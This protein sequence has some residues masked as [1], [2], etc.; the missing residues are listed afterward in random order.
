MTHCTAMIRLTRGK[1][2]C[3]LSAVVL[4]GA[5]GLGGALHVAYTRPIGM[6][7]TGETLPSHCSISDALKREARVSNPSLVQQPDPNRLEL[8][9]H[10]HCFW[11]QT[12]GADGIDRRILA[13]HLYDHGKRAEAERTFSEQRQPD[14]RVVTGLGDRA[15]VADRIPDDNMQVTLVVLRDTRVYKVIY[16]G[17]DRGFFFDRPFPVEEGERITRK[18]VE[19][20]LG[21]VK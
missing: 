14:E 11:R 4:L 5:L 18:V 13:I 20:L 6:P 1:L 8:V 19:E 16:R 21:A 10:T 2:T 12:V 15:T 3:L 7:P 17:A 9:R